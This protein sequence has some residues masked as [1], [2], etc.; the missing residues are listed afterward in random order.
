MQDQK[1]TDTGGGGSLQSLR[2]GSSYLI[3]GVSSVVGAMYVASSAALVVAWGAPRGLV[4]AT[5][6]RYVV[7]LISSSKDRLTDERQPEHMLD[8]KHYLKASSL[9][10]SLLF[11]P[12]HPLLLLTHTYTH[13]HETKHHSLGT[14]LF[15]AGAYS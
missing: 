2:L 1:A 10:L 5:V 13:T 9:L 14:R 7:L 15:Y 12:P 11:P 3:N 8:R 6:P 4:A